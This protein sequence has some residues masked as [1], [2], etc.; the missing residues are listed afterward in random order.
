MSSLSLI[1]LCN[2]IEEAICDSLQ[3]TYWIRAE[4]A[5]LTTR[6]G[7]GYW[8]L[9]DKGQSGILS[10]KV[11]ATCWSSIYGMLQAY[12][13][14]QTGVNLEV[15]M[16]V[17]VEVEVS[18]HAVYGLSLNIINIDPQ[19]TTGDLKKQRDLTIQKLQQEGIWD[20]QRMLRLPSLIKR[21]AIISSSKAAGYE[22]FMHQLQ[23]SPYAFSTT[24][25]E[26]IMQGDQAENS[27]IAALN[28]AYECADDYDIVVIIRGGGSTTDL[29][30]FDSYEVAAHCAQFPLPIFTGIGH[31]K[32]ISITDMVAHSALKTPTAVAADLISRMDDQAKIL[33][34]WRQRL[35]QTAQRQILIRRHVLE[36]LNQRLTM[37]NPEYIYHMGYSLATVDGRVIMSVKDVQP[38]DIITTHLNDGETQSTVL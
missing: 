8:E 4:I 37:R 7:H 31:T 1:E 26:A 25:Y 13:R 19:Y 12:F 9:V 5:S 22:D 15:G 10:A 28:A 11:R 29:T 18:F 3:P 32:D 17:L 35:V 38:G 27:L 33:E 24:L 23:A 16:Q 20:M 2:R 34:Q 6:G 36:L 30:C 21:I 14:E